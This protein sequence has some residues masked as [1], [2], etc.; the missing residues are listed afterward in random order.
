MIVKLRRLLS[1]ILSVGLASGSF[2]FANMNSVVDNN[3][4]SV[5]EAAEIAC[6]EP[7]GNV[8]SDKLEFKDCN[9][10]NIEK[11]RNCFNADDD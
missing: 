3:Y 2:C 1:S 6:T 4:P 5:E 10:E 9:F 7:E 11:C 8:K